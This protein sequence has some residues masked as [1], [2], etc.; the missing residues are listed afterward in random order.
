VGKEDIGILVVE[1]KENEFF[2]ESISIIPR[3]QNRRIGKAI[4]SELCK[5]AEKKGVS[6][7]LSVLKTNPSINLYKRLGFQEV[8]V[9]RHDIYMAKA[10]T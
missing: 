1:E 10:Y 4:L 6:V 8:K 5:K 2:L 7:R 3:L 9:D